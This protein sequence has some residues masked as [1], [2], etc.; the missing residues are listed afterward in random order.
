MKFISSIFIMLT[1]FS[2]LNEKEELVH[3]TGKTMGTYYSVKVVGSNVVAE[4]LKIQV[5]GLL[6]EVNNVFSTYIDDSELSRLNKNQSLT[7]IK[8][9]PVLADVLKLSKEI[10]KSSDGAFDVTVGPLVNMWGF[11]P[12]KIIERPTDEEIKKKMKAIGSDNFKIIEDSIVKSKENLY[13][14]LSAIAKGQAVDDVALVLANKGFKSFL[15]EIGGEVRA[16]GQ[17]PDGSKWR[18]GIEKPSKQLGQ[19]IQKVVVLDKMSIA[20]SGGY[21]NYLKYG[22]EVFSHTINP[23]TG[24]PVEHKLVSVSVL[25]ENC[26]VADA[27]ATAFMVLGAEKGLDIANRL[28]LKAYFLVKTDEGFKEIQSSLF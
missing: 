13:I 7:P 4:D 26:A 1:L 20:T 17:K 23:K 15:V 2:C 8:I 6:K 11:G 19:A 12:D 21:R 25:N 3:I 16:Q 5:D 18:V 27:W 28:G 14:D 9:T 10:Y 22:D 24:T